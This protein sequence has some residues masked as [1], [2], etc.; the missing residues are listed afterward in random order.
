MTNQNGYLFSDESCD[1]TFFI[2]SILLINRR[3]LKVRQYLDIRVT[4]SQSE[5]AIAY[6]YFLVFLLFVQQCENLNFRLGK[7][8]R[9]FLLQISLI[10]EAS[11]SLLQPN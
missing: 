2:Y 9:N 11:V 4:D 3:L 8:S 1:R 6:F 7:T 10:I 5:D